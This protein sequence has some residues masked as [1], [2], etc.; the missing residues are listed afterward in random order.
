MKTFAF[1]MASVVA[2]SIAL[3]LVCIG[4][5]GYTIGSA[6]KGKK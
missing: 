2:F 6:V 3:M 1:E 5:A 4:Y